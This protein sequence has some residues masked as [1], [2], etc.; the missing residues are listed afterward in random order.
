MCDDDNEPLFDS[1]IVVTD[2]RALDKQLQDAIYQ[3]EHEAGVVQKIDE[4]SQQLADAIAKKRRIIITTLQKFPFIIEKVGEFS[5]GTYGIIIDEAHSSQGGKAST[6]MMNVLSDK[7]LEDAYEADKIMEEELDSTEE[8]I[9]ETIEKS[10]K[11]DNMSFFA[12]TA[13]MKPK[14]I[15]KFGTYNPA[16][17]VPEPFH[18]YSMRQAIEEKFI[19]DVLQN[20]VTYETFYKMAKSIEDDPEVSKRKA[21]KEIA[22]YVSLHPHSIA[23]KTAIIIEHFRQSVR[24]KI[25]GQ[26][27]AMLVTRSRLH[28]VR[29][30][31]AFDQYIKANHYTDLNTLIV[32]SGTVDDDGVEYTEAE[33]NQISEKELP[34]KFSTDEYQVL[35]V[36]EKYQ[37]GFD[38]PLLHTMYV[39]KPLSGIKAVQTLSRLNRICPGKEETFVLDFV[40][41]PEDI[42]EAFQAY[43]EVT[44]L[45]EVTDPNILYDLKFELDATQVYTTNE[46]NVVSELQFQGKLKDTRNQAQLNPIL[47]QATDRFKNDLTKELQ[48]QFKSSA[49][50]FLRTYS[51]VLQIGPFTDVDLHKLYVYLNYLLRKLPR[52][53]SEDVYIADDIALEYYRNDKVFEGSINLDVKGGTE[54]EPTKHAGSTAPEEEIEKLSSIIDRIN[55]RFGTD[56]TNGDRLMKEL[57]DGMLKNDV[58]KQT[59]QNNTYD[60]FRFSFTKELNDFI[61]ENIEVKN[62]FMKLLANREA[63]LFVDEILSEK[64]Y[65]ELRERE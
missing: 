37:T 49:T 12:F 57:E 20:Y 17:G 4:D 6:A 47:D 58:V 26:A 27:K 24:H 50:K 25:G 62:D 30:K 51:F 19:L 3:H 42:Q 35:I 65:E 55:E 38:E 16:T 36:A 39:D 13:T 29:Y 22:R 34:E 21:S 2:R 14:T 33:M 10:G 40:N 11:Q 63:L 23:Q 43:Y 54:L 15:E 28:A 61:V 31:L 52:E 32:F 41:D 48:D 45:S 5:R 7:T 64:V 18:V 8:K 9:V 44:A 60:N 56:F 1:I 59:V 46:L 53:V